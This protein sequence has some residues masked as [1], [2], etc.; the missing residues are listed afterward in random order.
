MTPLENAQS[1]G[2][3]GGL[4]VVFALTA[5]HPV[6]GGGMIRIRRFLPHLARRGVEAFVLAGPLPGHPR[7]ERVDDHE[8]VRVR[9]CP[10]G[11]LGAGPVLFAATIREL[12]SL[13]DRFDL[14]HAVGVSWLQMACLAIGPILGRPVIVEPTL[15]GGDD[16]LA[17]ASLRSAPLWSRLY[18]RADRVVALSSALAEAAREAGIDPSRIVRIPNGI[19][20][21]RFTPVRDEAERRALRAALRI[22]ES[23]TLT[24][25]VGELSERKG[26]D[27]L[28]DAWARVAALQSDAQLA[29]VGPVRPTAEGRHFLA[30]QRERISRLGLAGRVHFPGPLDRIEDALRAADVFALATRSEGLPNVVLE[31]MAC[32][33]PAVV[34]D[35]PGISRDIIRSRD[36][37]RCV[38][39]R[40]GEAFA[41]AIVELLAD[42][43]QRAAVGAA[44]RRR[45]VEEFSARERA[46]RCEELYRSL[47]G[48]E[49]DAAQS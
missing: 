44:A 24:V 47:L 19:D 28:V 25:M 13:R 29:L 9:A 38:E 41:S 33:L 48:R 22:P 10:A 34:T 39:P 20:V 18:R 46:R 37:G 30:R 15:L 14:I 17:V 7:R 27:V 36:E 4:R 3:E 2:R 35:L 23:G 1:A 26:V 31:A 8:L 42:P 49:A 12:V 16:P 32:G 6:Y 45:V 11:R 21:E 43:A 5:Y 40:S